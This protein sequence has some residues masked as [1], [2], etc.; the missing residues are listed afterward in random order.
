MARVSQID[1]KKINFI[2]YLLFVLCIA[3][4]SVFV[5]THSKYKTDQTNAIIYSNKLYKL[6]KDNLMISYSSNNTTKEELAAVFNFSSNASEINAQ[7]SEMTYRLNVQE[8]CRIESIEPSGGGKILQPLNENLELKISGTVHVRLMCEKAKIKYNNEPDTYH[9]DVLIYGKVGEEKEFIYQQGMLIQKAPWIDPTP[10]IPKDSIEIEDNPIESK[11]VY[12]KLLEWLKSNVDEFFKEE[13]TVYRDQIKGY[14]E[15][16]T[17]LYADDN[18]EESIRGLDIKKQTVAGGTSYTFTLQENFFG[19]A[20]TSQ[21]IGSGPSDY[22]YLYFYVDDKDKMYEILEYYL[23]TYIYPDQLENVPYIIDYL[24]G[25]DI[26]EYV[27]MSG[28]TR[29]TAPGTAFYPNYMMIRNKESLLNA[30][31]TE[32]GI[33]SDEPSS[34]EGIPPLDDPKEKEPTPSIPTSNTIAFGTK[35]EMLTSFEDYMKN[36]RTI[37]PSSTL[38]DEAIEK[39]IN[40]EEVR[41][42]I[43]KNNDE[44]EE[45]QSFKDYFAFLDEVTGNYFI[46]NPS[47]SGQTNQMQVDTIALTREQ[48][49]TLE[50]VNNIDNT[51]TITFT[52]DEIVSEQPEEQDRVDT[53]L[54]TEQE[55]EKMRQIVTVLDEYFKESSVEE[56]LESLLQKENGILTFTY[57]IPKEVEREFD[58]TSIL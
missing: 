12:P 11:D 21:T 42:S 33:G 24:K 46:V 30:A 26:A 43:I 40:S 2:L 38:S 58:S 29:P 31:L 50:L 39:V 56:D 35:E 16:Y 53:S 18:F 1:Q 34:D 22:S 49:K 3:N 8:G 55:K 9:V 6:N 14:V 32:A 48:V 5:T 57:T 41:S 25:K 13:E 54:I 52:W 44:M 45:K 36:I 4:S 37:D 7:D 28:T 19:Y 20:R 10:D 47:S 23:K 17:S 51:L 27:I 15:Q